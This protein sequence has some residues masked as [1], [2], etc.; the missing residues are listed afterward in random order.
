MLKSLFLIIEC[1][2]EIA[3]HIVNLYVTGIR[4][5]CMPGQTGSLPYKKRNFRTGSNK[6]DKF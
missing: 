5:R 4:Y 1:L 2:S 3:G 6:D